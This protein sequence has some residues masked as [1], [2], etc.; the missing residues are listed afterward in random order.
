MKQPTINEQLVRRYLLNDLPRR[1]RERLEVG[2]LTDDHYFE[3]LTA[4]EGEVEDHLIDEYLDGELTGTEKENFERVFLNTPERAHKIKVIRELKD[5]A[6]VAAR[7]EAP[8]S[9]IV[10]TDPTYESWI[11]ATAIF[12]NP[13]FGLSSAAALTLALLCCVWLWMR[14]NNLEAQ[15]RQARAEHPT[16]TTLKDQ[17]D[18]LRR[19]NEDLQAKLRYSEEQRAGLEQSLASLRKPEVPSP[20]KS[21]PPTHNTF[22]SVILS[23][24]LR[25]ASANNKSTLTLQPG[26]TEGRLVINVERVNPKD[27]KRFRAIVRKQSGPEVWRNENVKLQSSRNNAHAVL[28]ISAEKLTDGQYVGELEG[29]TSDEQSETL[30]LYVFRVVHK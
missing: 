9:K 12:Q 28:S 10:K 20:D 26:H 15:L 23:P 21:L 6:A 5:Q 25:S 2:L 19:N 11:P 14:S 1:E 27:Y 16:E 13:L 24:G 18:Q 17:V 7:R 3:T 4:L 30:G 8:V 22:A 29:I